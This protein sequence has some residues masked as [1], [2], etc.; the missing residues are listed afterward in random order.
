MGKI[1]I[2]LVFI[3]MFLLDCKGEVKQNE[4]QTGTTEVPAAPGINVSI[5]E[6]KSIATAN[7]EM[8]WLDVRTPE[9]IALGKIDGA[10][11]MDFNDPAFS[12]KVGALDKEKE[13]VVYCAAGGRSAR[14]VELMQQMGFT[15]IHNMTEG[16]TG[17]SQQ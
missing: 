5:S 17:W 16:Y 14:A 13:Y 6:A 4:P 3:S 10:V 7:A 2:F 12:E 1:S 11:E 15:N 8:V 9:E